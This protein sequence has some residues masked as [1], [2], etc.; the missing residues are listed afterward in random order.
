MC[1][2]NQQRSVETDL[3]RSPAVRDRL[4]RS[5]GALLALG[6]AAVPAIAYQGPLVHRDPFAAF[7]PLAPVALEGLR[8]GFVNLA[9][10]EFDFGAN[11]RTYIDGALALETLVRFTEQGPIALPGALSALPAN[12]SGDQLARVNQALQTGASVAPSAPGNAPSAPAGTANSGSVAGNAP[13]SLTVGGSAAEAAVS[14]GMP[15]SLDQLT[16]ANVDLSGLADARGVVVN[17]ARGFTAALHQ[18]TRQ[19][20]ASFLVSTANARNL[21]QEIDVEVTV[22]NFKAYQSAARD[23]LLGNR[24]QAVGRR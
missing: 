5:V 9:G 22:N 10:L 15:A 16:P 14:N 7:E 23:A 20:I 18:V 2:V 11:V 3:R 1:T 24:W 13:A 12:I 4:R 21:R 8:G 6:L 17:D 19:R